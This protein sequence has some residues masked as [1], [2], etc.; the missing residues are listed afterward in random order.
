M[1]VKICGVTNQ[2]DAVLCEESGADAIGFVNV[3]GRKRSIALEDIAA[4]CAT[5]GPLTA[6]VLVCEPEDEE[7]AIGMCDMAGTDVLQTYTLSPEQVSAVRSSGFGVIRA[8]RPDRAEAL[9]YRDAADA[10]LFEGGAPGTGEEY[11]YSSIPI[12]ACPRAIIAG[13]LTPS[14][15]DR[16]KSLGPYALDVSSGVERTHGRKDP[17]LVRDFIRRCKA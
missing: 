4:I 3:P 15:L 13:G 7:Q 1:K 6:K 10:I 14:N 5:L 12:D 16:A 8:I 11:D 2:E 9:R 17:E